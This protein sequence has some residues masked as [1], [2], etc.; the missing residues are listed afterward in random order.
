MQLLRNYSA[1]MGRG[2]ASVAC[3]V[4]QSG[5]RRALRSHRTMERQRYRP[6]RRNGQW[7]ADPLDVHGN[8][9]RLVSLDGRIVTA[10]R[11]DMEA[12]W[13][14]SCPSAKALSRKWTRINANRN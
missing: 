11:P 7:N 1:R 3:D 5:D 9:A 14:V 8:C 13:R 6:D 12:G 4:V 10:G 2:P